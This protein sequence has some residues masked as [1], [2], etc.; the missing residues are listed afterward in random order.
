MTIADGTPPV[1]GRGTRLR[2]VVE[3][4]GRAAPSVVLLNVP[5]G[6]GQT[7]FLGALATAA[8]DEGWRVV[9]ADADGE[10]TVARDTRPD[11]F[12]KRLRDA[13]D[14]AEPS[15]ITGGT[16]D[17]AVDA[18]T[19]RPVQ[20]PVLEALREHRDR[21]LLLLDG[22]RPSPTF[23]AWFRDTFVGDLLAHG[24]AAVVVAD[25]DSALE[26]FATLPHERVTLGALDRDEVR[27]LFRAL[28]PTTEPPL[29]AEEIEQ[30]TEASVWRPDVVGALY[31][32]L[33]L[34]MRPGQRS[35]VPTV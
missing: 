17:F 10:F 33:T 31:R 1:V 9:H 7:T 22:F 35:L 19:Q 4:L 25:T 2:Q 21:W 15:A 14:V 12:A 27:D 20:D 34:P 6:M 28:A 26:P 32:L 11:A 13:L 16:R 8:T 29:T 23:A 5:A 3:A 30:Y 24:R 18:S